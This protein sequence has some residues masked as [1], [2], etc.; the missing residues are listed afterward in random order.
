MSKRIEDREVDLTT[1]NTAIRDA[2]ILV[3][4][5]DEAT[6]NLLEAIFILPGYRVE[7]TTNGADA[8][9]R[10][11]A[12]GFDLLVTERNLPRLNGEQLV[13]ALREA[14]IRIPVIV[15]SGSLAERPLS[16]RMA[17]EVSAALPK[18]VRATE[19][20]AA[21]ITALNSIPPQLRSA[22]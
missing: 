5:D 6:R 7:T 1:F 18:P 2:R 16:A 8:L 14:G 17:M 11:T 13:I 19:V 4:E 20:L 21:I 10:L 22:A 3:V 15:I 9:A 12:R